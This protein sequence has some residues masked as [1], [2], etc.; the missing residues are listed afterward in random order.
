MVVLRGVAADSII[1]VE[2]ELEALLEA[3]LAKDWLTS[4]NENA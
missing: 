2:V 3:R 1:E 4:A